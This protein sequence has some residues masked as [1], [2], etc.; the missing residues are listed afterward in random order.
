MLDGVK[1]L[2]PLA[3]SAELLIVGARLEGHG[4]VLFLVETKARGVL[5]KAAPGMGVRAAATGDVL[6]EDVRLPA[7]CA[8]R[9]RA[10]DV[11]AAAVRRA[12]LAWCGARRSAPRAR[13]S[14]T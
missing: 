9:R 10:P 3:E 7:Q 11:Y 6:L 14:T 1:S 4:P 8:A 12:R 5:V 2:V 13:C